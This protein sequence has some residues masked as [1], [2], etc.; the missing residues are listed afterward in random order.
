MFQEILCRQVLLSEL[1]FY[2]VE[3]LDLLQ[4]FP[5]GALLFFDLGSL[6]ELSAHMRQTAHMSNFH[7]TF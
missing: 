7:V 2:P 4:G 6:M 5:G 1:L 3:D